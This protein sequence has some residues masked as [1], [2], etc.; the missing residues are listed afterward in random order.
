[1]T[2]G[3]RPSASGDAHNASATASTLNHALGR[4]HIKSWMNGASDQPSSTP[5]I[6]P[7][8]SSITPNPA[9]PVTFKKRGRP[10]KYPRPEEHD[11]VT[12]L[13]DTRTT[14]TSPAE[15]LPPSNSTSPQLA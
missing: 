4:K 9:H 11:T 6:P 5:S 2:A 15:R 14:T 10:R 12:S 7:T 8:P 13:V 3:A 1:M